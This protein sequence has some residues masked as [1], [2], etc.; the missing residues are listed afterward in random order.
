MLTGPVT[1]L[2]WSFVRDDQPLG[3]TADQVAL[4]LR[5]EIDDL[6]AAGARVVQVDEPA[7][8]ELLPLRKEQQPDYLEWAVGSFRLA[9]SGAE[10]KVQIHT[11]MCYSEFN[12]LIDTVS[13]LD[14]DVTSIEA[15]RNGMQVL[16]AL[17]DEGYEL[18]VGPGV[19]DIHSPRVPKQEEVDELLTAALG[20]VDPSLLWVNPDCGLKTRGWEETTASLEVLVAAA[21]KA[22]AHV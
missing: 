9:T 19:W 7:I 2:A 8:R 21:K 3:V 22:R 15:A 14:A 18:G 17:K 11:H 5:D 1:M 4:A 6:I 13:N 16:A 20:S 12:E 10:N